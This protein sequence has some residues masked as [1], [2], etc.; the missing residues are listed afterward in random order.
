MLPSFLSPV[1]FL[2]T[3]LLVS[4][5]I[6]IELSIS[7]HEPTIYCL[8]FVW[9]LNVFSV[10]VL[11]NFFFISPTHLGS[12][13]LTLLL[14]CR[15]FEMG[16]ASNS[17]THLPL[18]PQICLLSVGIKSATTVIYLL[19]GEF[20]LFTFSPIISTQSSFFYFIFMI[21]VFPCFPFSLFC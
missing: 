12:S 5:M 1:W 2:S 6:T 13:T 4:Y 9:G 8:L 7:R 14:P 15:L 11:F 21:A 3:M 17:E 16:L 10:S 18:S 20:N 19:T